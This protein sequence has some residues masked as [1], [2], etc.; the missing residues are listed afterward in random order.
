[1]NLMRLATY[2]IARLRYSDAVM[3]CLGLI[4]PLLCVR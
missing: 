4:E 1:M 2:F 3:L